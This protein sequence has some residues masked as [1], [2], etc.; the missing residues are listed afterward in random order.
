V[1]KTTIEMMEPILL[2]LLGAKAIQFP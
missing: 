2:F 1:G